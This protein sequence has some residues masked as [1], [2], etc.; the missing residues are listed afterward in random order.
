MQP[1]LDGFYSWYARD[2][3]GA[4]SCGVTSEKERATELLVGALKTLSPGASGLVR[5][6]RL[7]RRARHPSYRHGE[8]LL[9]TQRDQTTTHVV[10]SPDDCFRRRVA[11]LLTDAEGAG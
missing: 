1:D 11:R 2:D 6:V 10:I 7:E 3:L 4:G 9:R 8:V 5:T